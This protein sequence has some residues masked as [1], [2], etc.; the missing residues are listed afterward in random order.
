MSSPLSMLKKMRRA[1]LWGPRKEQGHKPKVPFRRNLL[2]EFQEGLIADDSSVCNPPSSSHNPVDASATKSKGPPKPGAPPSDFELMSSMMQRVTLLEQTV[3][4]QQQ[5]IKHKERKIS[6]L[7]RRLKAQEESGG[8]GSQSGRD[9][10]ERRCKQLQSQVHEMEDFLN[11]YGLIWVGEGEMSDPADTEQTCDPHPGQPGTSAHGSFHMNFDL[12]VQRIRELNVL[13]GEGESFVQSTATGAKLAKKE[14]VQLRLYSNGVVMFDGPFRSFQEDSARQ[15]MQDLMDGYFPSELQ[16]RFPDGVPFQVHDLR[17]QEFT[18]RL[19]AGAFPGEGQAVGGEEEETTNAAF[20]RI[21]G[22]KLTLDRFLNKLPR[23]VVR[24]GRVV[25]VREPLRAM[26][27]QGSQDAQSSCPPI[28][29]HT[30]A[31]AAMDRSNTALCDT[32]RPERAVVTLKLR[33]EDGSEAYI[34]RMYLSETVGQLR[35]HLDRHR[36]AG[37]PGYHIISAFPQQSFDDDS[38]T[39][40]SCGLSTNATLLLRKAEHS[41]SLAEENKGTKVYEMG[42]FAFLLH[43]GRKDTIPVNHAK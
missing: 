37:R 30:P 27:G 35:G 22:R 5:E 15:C 7:E 43:R 21:P 12:V 8:A 29:I 32:R 24:A 40:G 13:A 33:S 25:E 42:E 19:P 36:G 23:S 6:V 39:L 1:P 17:H 3:K 10:L 4:H 26:L 11:D 38:R 41:H 28:L 18:A 2:Q 34:V 16:Q 31:Q 14:P 9:D 20:H